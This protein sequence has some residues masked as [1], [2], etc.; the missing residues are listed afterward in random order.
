MHAFA[1]SLGATD[2]MAR[3]PFTHTG[4]SDDAPRRIG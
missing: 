3:R 1:T 2:Q 4:T